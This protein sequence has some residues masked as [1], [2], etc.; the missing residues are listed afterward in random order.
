MEFLVRFLTSAGLL[1]LLSNAVFAKSTMGLGHYYVDTPSENYQFTSLS[2][3]YRK[4]SF[5]AKLTVPFIQRE[6]FS[7][8]FG[9]PLLKLSN[10]WR[11][12]RGSKQLAL[13]YKQK[14]PLAND[15]ATI[16]VSDTAIGFEY[17]QNLNWG[18]VT[19]LEGGHWWRDSVSYTRKNSL[20][21][22]VGIIK[23]FKQYVFAVLADNKPTALGDEDSMASIFIRKKLTSQLSVS[24][25][26]AKGLNESSPNNT[27]GLQLHQFF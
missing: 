16:A 27:L 17:S 4:T 15:K 14:I 7:N 1:A 23:S 21:A 13:I 19:F 25:L 22:T 6:A 2:M 3:G 5:K 24:F 26:Y 9:N 11:F 20:Y 10:S 12:E 18:M 8:G